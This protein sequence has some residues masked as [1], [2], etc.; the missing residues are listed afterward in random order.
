M[1]SGLFEQ[2]RATAR[3]LM[4]FEDRRGPRLRWGQKGTAGWWYIPKGGAT[5]WVRQGKHPAMIRGHYYVPGHWYPIVPPKEHWPSR[6]AFNGIA[7]HTPMTSVVPD[8]VRTAAQADLYERQPGE[9]SARSEVYRS[10]RERAIGF[11]EP[12]AGI[13]VTHRKPSR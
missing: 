9:P 7:G 5:Y 1:G 4:D 6:N 10:R 12:R 13:R 8:D 2:V 11:A 3:R